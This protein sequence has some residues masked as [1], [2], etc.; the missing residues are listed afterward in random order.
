MKS[1]RLA[2][3]LIKRADTLQLVNDVATGY[4][5]SDGGVKAFVANLANAQLSPAVMNSY[6]KAVKKSCYDNLENKENIGNIRSQINK[7]VNG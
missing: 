7:Q 2:I 4:F 6:T 1:K 5:K 3:N